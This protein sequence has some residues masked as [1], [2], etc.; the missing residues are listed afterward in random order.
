MKRVNPY[1]NT[2]NQVD[3]RCSAHIRLPLKVTEDN[4]NESLPIILMRLTTLA[5]YVADTSLRVSF[6][7]Q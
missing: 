6:I 2:V 4:E 3:E 5:N 1:V 7:W